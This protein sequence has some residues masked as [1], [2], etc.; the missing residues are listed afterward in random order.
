MQQTVPSPPNEQEAALPP[1]NIDD[2]DDE[3]LIRILKF[4]LD[5]LV[6]SGRLEKLMPE[7]LKLIPMVK[8]LVGG[9]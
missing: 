7:L 5:Q 3:Q 1:I 2:I 4:L 6:K 8:E 9:L